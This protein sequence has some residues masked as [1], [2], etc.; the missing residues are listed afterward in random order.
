MKKLCIVILFS[1]VIVC[2]LF[3]GKAFNIYIPCFLNYITGLYCPGCGLT[4]ML[5]SMLKGD[6]YQ[7]FRFNP[8]MFIF[9][10]FIFLLTVD[11]FI[12]SFSKRKSILARIPNVVWYFLI[13]VFILYGIMRNIP[14]FDYL[15]PTSI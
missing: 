1:C 11:Y 14:Y 2:Y 8:L 3:L 4:R 9:M 5:Y 15:K 10:P 6:F 12:S 7:A 13:V